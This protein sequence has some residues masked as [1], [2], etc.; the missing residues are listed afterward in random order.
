MIPN[1]PKCPKIFLFSCFIMKVYIMV[2][3]YKKK[4]P[5]QQFVC[6]G[7]LYEHQKFSTC[8]VR[9]YRKVKTGKADA[10]LSRYDVESV[11]SQD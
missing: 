2:T 5:P 4:K 9:L 3:K 1:H 10:N 7:F 11:Y 8:T 6:F